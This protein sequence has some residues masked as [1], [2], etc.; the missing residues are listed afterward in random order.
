MTA[1]ILEISAYYHDSA[2][3]LLQDGAVV[4]AVQE[5]LFSRK[6]K[7]SHF[8]RNVI[9][10]CLAPA[11]SHRCEFPLKTARTVL[12]ETVTTSVTDMLNTKPP[13]TQNYYY[14]FSSSIARLNRQL[15]R[16]GLTFAAHIKRRA[17]FSDYVVIVGDQHKHD[18]ITNCQIE[19]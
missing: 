17:E 15:F 4:A 18:L 19:K 11:E 2:A 3:S 13:V 7:D 14:A 5:E 1:R 9:H 12:T 8:P 16:T 6:K 10:Y